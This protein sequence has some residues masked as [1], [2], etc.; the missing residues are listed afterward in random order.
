[1]VF[2][3]LFIFSSEAEAASDNNCLSKA[4]STP[5]GYG[6]VAYSVLSSLNKL[7]LILWQTLPSQ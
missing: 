7:H 3:C 2:F 4:S 6:V 5:L 1:M